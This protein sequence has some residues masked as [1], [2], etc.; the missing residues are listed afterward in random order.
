[1]RIQ[2]ASVTINP[3][4]PEGGAVG[5]DDVQIHLCDDENLDESRK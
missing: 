2:D 4:D 5:L 1:M 3:N